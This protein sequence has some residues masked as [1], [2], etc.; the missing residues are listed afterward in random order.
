MK[1]ENPFGE[2]EYIRFDGSKVIC[3]FSYE[4]RWQIISKIPASSFKLVWSIDN[5]TDELS[6]KIE[7]VESDEK[8][9][10][11][12]LVQFEDQTEEGRDVLALNV[13]EA[14]SLFLKEHGVIDVYQVREA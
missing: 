5:A 11:E 14:T 9:T 7:T 13:E 2:L 3:K 10:F 12:G 1:S 8:R 6:A 4:S